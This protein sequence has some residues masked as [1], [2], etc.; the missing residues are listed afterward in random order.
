MWTSQYAENPGSE[1]VRLRVLERKHL[2]PR[3]TKEG[4]PCCAGLTVRTT[5]GT[6]AL[7]HL[8]VTRKAA[9][10]ERGPEQ[11]RAV[12][13]IGAA[14]QAAPLLGPSHS[15]AGVVLEAL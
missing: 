3:I 14:G 13:L 4:A 6:I 9:P 15:V 11:E 5:Y 12:W 1:Q 2:T 8:L 7:T 10:F